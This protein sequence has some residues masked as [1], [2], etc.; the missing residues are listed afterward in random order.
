MTITEDDEPKEAK[1]VPLPKLSVITG[2]RDSTGNWLINLQEGS[3]FLC[4]LRGTSKDKDIDF[5]LLQFHIKK[6]WQMGVWLHSNFPYN[7]AG[8][9]IV[10]SLAFSQH[11]ELVELLQDGEPEGDDD[12]VR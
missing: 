4:R 1:V 11:H 5:I 7:Q 12:G 10:H 8:D 3:V 6:K 2:G 9:F